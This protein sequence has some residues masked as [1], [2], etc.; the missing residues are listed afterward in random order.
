MKIAL[1]A[2]PWLPLPP[3][4]YGG[5][6]LVVSDLADGLVDVGQDVTL[7]A[8][9]DSQSKARIDSLLPQHIGQDWPGIAR[10]INQLWTQAAY[11]RAL[12]QGAQVIH[13]HTFLPTDLDIPLV[14]TLHGP[15][16]PTRDLPNEQP[17]A[18]MARKW[19]Q[20]GPGRNYFVAISRRQ[21]E[22]YGEG[23]N[24]VGVVHNAMDAR[25][26]PFSA[27]KEDYFFFIGRA[28]WSK[29]I[30]LAARV[31]VKAK[32]RLIM[33][34]KMT[35]KHERTYFD[36]HIGPLLDQGDITLLEEVTPRQKFELYSKAACTLFT[37]RWEEPFGLVMT[38]SMATGTPVLALPRGA[39]PEVIVD[40]VTGYLR[41]GEEGLV[42]AAALVDQLDPMAC[43]R[44]IEENFSVTKMVA[45]Y[46]QAYKWAL[47]GG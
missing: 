13:G 29:G 46:E 15:A 4:G 27:E 11:A 35:E 19:S 2:P 12:A 38:E 14:H 41:D 42:E 24:W 31:A 33:A 26:I 10:V 28:S 40:G 9:G 21:Q 45:G 17:F 47:A 7:F 6:E 39:A 3:T 23:I 36:E 18:D 20:E 8:S 5:I 22:L 37:S 34:V 16:G 30:D 1:V 44:H 32:R 43:R 25:K